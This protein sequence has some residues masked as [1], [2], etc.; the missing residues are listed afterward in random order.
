MTRS[1]FL[2]YVRIR[3]QSGE[4]LADIG[5]DFGV[6]F[7]TVWR[8]LAGKNGPSGAVCRVADFVIQD[9]L[10]RGAKRIR[11]EIEALIARDKL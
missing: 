8:W 4:T 1:S 11:P 9:Q 2:E 10:A 5:A 7:M 6:G 3:R